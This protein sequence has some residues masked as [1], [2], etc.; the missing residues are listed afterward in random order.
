VLSR[1]RRVAPTSTGRRHQASA[2]GVAVLVAAALGLASCGEDLTPPDRPVA[3]ELPSA[4][5]A[6]TGT[7]DR[8]LTQ[9]D[10]PPGRPPPVT[11]RADGAVVQ[12]GRIYNGEWVEGAV[13]RT[14]RPP[15]V[16]PWPAS[17]PVPPGAALA[18]DVGTAALPRAITVQAVTGRLG[19]TGE[20]VTAPVAVVDCAWEDIIDGRPPCR[21]DR[22]SGHLR[23][24]FAAVGL[25]RPRMRLA[26][27]VSWLVPP[28]PGTR[29]LRTSWATWLLSI[30]PTTG[31]V[32]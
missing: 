19:R 26:V 2:T 21:F 12:D 11:L 27:N 30:R 25:A 32:G 5:A 23:L 31:G 10:T 18:L 24:P 28:V 1:L 8:L 3:P 6:A 14:I 29:G 17:A 20:P 4:V 9:V 13:A 16:V 22:G 15:R 7:G